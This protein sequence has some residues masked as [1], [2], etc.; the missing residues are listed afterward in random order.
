MFNLSDSKWIPVVLK[1]GGHRGRTE[2]S[3]REALVRSDRVLRFD[4]PLETMVPALL[5]HLFLPVVMRAA[6]VPGDESDWASRFEDGPV[7][8]G[9]AAHVERYLDDWHD[10]FDLFDPERPFAQIGVGRLPAEDRAEGLAKLVTTSATGNNVPL[11]TATVE[12]QGHT[13]P[14][15][16]AA[17]W[18]VHTLCWDT[19]G[20]KPSP[21]D[22]VG[23]GPL[24][25]LGV[26]IPEG[27]NLFETIMLN[28]PIL[29]GGLEPDDLPHWELPPRI[30][31]RRV[32]TDLE[33]GHRVR[34]FTQLSRSIRLVPDDA[35]E[36]RSVV[37]ALVFPGIEYT[38]V[39][40]YEPHTV[41]ARKGENEQV[42]FVP[43]RHPYEHGT[44][45]GL[46]S[47][48]ALPR[49]LAVPGNQNQ[50]HDRIERL[51]RQL[52]TVAE[53]AKLHLPNDFPLQVS[54]YGAKYTS[55][56]GRCEGIIHDR[57]PVPVAALMTE[58]DWPERNA[59]AVSAAQIHDMAEA[60]GRAWSHLRMAAGRGDNGRDATGL[61]PIDL[62][63]DRIDPLARR[64]L[65]ALQTCLGDHQAVRSALWQWERD[66]RDHTLEV[67]E[68]LLA[69][70]GPRAV[71]GRTV[72][73]EGGTREYSAA[74]A[75]IAIWAAAKRHLPLQWE[76]PEGIST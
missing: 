21:K 25:T 23:A 53:L 63:L 32:T 17:L 67:F 6:G 10:R 46:Q 28:L 49:R 48:L 69:M 13:M 9:L 38:A 7:R 74:G 72:D 44:W 33:P 55:P 66:L 2:L 41:W 11:F 42:K 12:G 70:V 16:E 1:D 58:R 39:P 19:G 68:E 29:G 34:L 30:Y 15:G 37:G 47:L 31:E 57:I 8:S 26:V 62:L 22:G 35:H 73:Y 18:L 52:Q 59:I 14:P 3:L 45:W 4:L 71:A 64:F 54:V 43:K 75:E 51:A 20:P 50:D 76:H 5:R 60:L 65:R 24:G 36:P 61:D 56:P 40:E 27:R